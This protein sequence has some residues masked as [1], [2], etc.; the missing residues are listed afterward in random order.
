M[1][2]LWIRNRSRFSIGCS[3]RRSCSTKATISTSEASSG[4]ATVGSAS[5]TSGARTRPNVSAASPAAHCSAPA[6]SIGG[7]SPPRSPSGTTRATRNSVPSTSGTFSAKIHRHEAA[8]HQL[9]ADQ[10]ADDHAD[11][12]PGRPRAHRLAALVAREGHDDHRQRRGRQQRPADALER[13]AQHQELDRGRHRAQDRG[14]PEADQ[15]G[16]EHP[17]LAQDVAQRAADQD[18]RGQRDQVGVGRPLLT[19]EA[20]AEVVADGRERHV[21]HRGVH[22]DDGGAQDAGHQDQALAVI[23]HHPSIAWGSR[24]PADTRRYAGIERHSER[25]FRYR[26]LSQPPSCRTETAGPIGAGRFYALDM[27]DAVSIREVG[28]ARR[29]PERARGH[30]DRGQDRADRPAGPHRAAPAGGHQ[31]R[32]GGRDPP[33]GRRRR[34]A[35]GHRRAGRGR[36]GRARAQRAR[37]GQRARPA[38]ALPARPTCSCRPP[39]RTTGRT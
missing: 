11:G 5:P 19:G 4:P 16:R 10:R 31:L 34:G 23:A 39:S 27:A 18:Q 12:A 37:A 24:F 15:P 35:A 25:V 29:V 7:W 32:P 3:V 26:R 6:T 28:P 21:D 8:V 36:G 17:P 13:A 9:A 33:A 22:G 30:P 38:R 2:K 14:H 1:A 20:A